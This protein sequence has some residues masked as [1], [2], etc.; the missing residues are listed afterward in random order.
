MYYENTCCSATLP[1][2][3]ATWPYFGL[4][5]GRRV[6]IRLLTIWKMLC[7]DIIINTFTNF[8]HVFR[9][10]IMS[11]VWLT[12]NGVWIGDSIYWRL[13]HDSELQVITAPPLISTI[14]K[15][16][17]QPLSLFQP[18]VSS[19]AVLW[20]LLLTVEIF[21]LHA[22]RSSLHSLPCRTQLNYPTNFVPFL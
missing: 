22:L 17:E 20:Q 2:I 7:R 8:V 19:P 5:P 11:R 9:V 4:N 16:P 21:Q 12:I 15:S 6:A 1:S 3:Y 13:I 10:L 18:A 14:H